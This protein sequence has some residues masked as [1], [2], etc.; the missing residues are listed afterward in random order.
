MK[1]NL[2]KTCNLVKKLLEKDVNN[3]E[4]NIYKINNICLTGNSIF[5]PNVLLKSKTK[6]SL[7]SS[8]LFLEFKNK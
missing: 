5:Y 8:S 6:L 1:I 3:R 2:F 7:N 4:I